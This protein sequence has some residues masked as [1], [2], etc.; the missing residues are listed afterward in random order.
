MGDTWDPAVYLR[1]ADHRSRPALELLARVDHPDPRLVHEIGAGGGDLAR[2]MAERWPAA[3]IVGSDSSPDMLAA[4]RDAGGRV[5]WQQLDVATW[6]PEPVHD[7]LL[8]NAVLHWMPNHAELFDRL[9]DGLA[10]GG[11]LAIQMPLSWS[12]PSHVLLRE[13]LASGHGD[14]ELRARFD[15]PWV[16]EPA[17][18]HE[19]LSAR[20]DHVDVWETRYHQVLHG[21]DPVLSWVSGTVLRPVLDALSGDAAE[22]FLADYGAALRHAYPRRADGTTVLPFPRLFLVGRVDSG[23]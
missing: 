19:V 11:W 2:L 18:Y 21:D 9:L 15:D 14:E 16:L 17:W 4:A 5:E 22:A 12:E 7:V 6:R 20:C 23:A 13:T 10:S 3:R 1:H 8:A